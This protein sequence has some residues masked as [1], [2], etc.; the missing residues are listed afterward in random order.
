MTKLGA[1]VITYQRPQILVETI[2]SIFAQTTPPDFV[3]I[4]DNSEDLETDHAVATL[5]DRRIRYHRMGFNA[6][7]AGAAAVGLQ[8]CVHDRA[9][10]IYWGDDNDPPFRADCFERLLA[11]REV[12]PFCG[13]LGAVGHF[14]D[15]KKGV[16]K[17]IQTRL[18]EKKEWVEVDSIAGGMCMLVS[19]ELVKAGVL[20]DKDLFFG[21]EELDFCL[22]ASRKGFALV[23][24]CAL[25]LEARAQAGRLEFERPVYQPKKNLSREYYSLRNLLFIS[26]TLTL[27]SMKKQLILK[28]TGKA[29]YGYRYGLGYGWENMRMIVLAFWH[30]FKGIKGKTIPLG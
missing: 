7:P 1:F 15:R 23:V 3:W 10:W 17:R 14:F 16:I 8:L 21:F 13:V 24:D 9:D 6:G 30:Y 27:N 2:Q 25:F 26:D 28:W 22:K 20:P 4:I 5:Q 29:F 11:I 19:A 18:L 12:N